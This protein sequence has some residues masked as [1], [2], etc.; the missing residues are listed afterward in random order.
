[1]ERSERPGYPISG[2]TESANSHG[3]GIGRGGNSRCTLGEVFRFVRSVGRRGGGKLGKSCRSCEG[4]RVRKPGEARRNA[5]F[6]LIGHFYQLL[7][8]QGG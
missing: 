8:N 1:M 2:V 7:W 6:A 4:T 5:P 3:H